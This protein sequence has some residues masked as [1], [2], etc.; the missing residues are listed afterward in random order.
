M[1]TGEGLHAIALF[2][3][4]STPTKLTMSGVEFQ[5]PV[6]SES[7]AKKVRGSSSS[8]GLRL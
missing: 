5:L 4:Q 2:T 7:P 8:L 3:S 1:S 6:G